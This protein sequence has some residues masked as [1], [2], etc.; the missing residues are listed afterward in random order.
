MSKVK[1]NGIKRSVEHDEEVK[2]KKQIIKN[3]KS[4]KDNVIKEVTEK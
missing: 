4:R 2:T 1:K 3:K